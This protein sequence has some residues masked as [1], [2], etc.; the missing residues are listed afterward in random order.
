MAGAR[1]FTLEEAVEKGHM[2]ENYNLAIAEE[3]NFLDGFF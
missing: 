2:N 1:C 3:R